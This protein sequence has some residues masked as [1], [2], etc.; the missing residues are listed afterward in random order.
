V[1]KIYIRLCA[2]SLVFAVGCDKRRDGSPAIEH[3]TSA[4]AAQPVAALTT[5]AVPLIKSDA[6]AS[7]REFATKFV[8]EANAVYA[9]SF[10]PLEP[11]IDVRKT[12]SLIAPIVGIVNISYKVRG[13]K[14][15]S[16]GEAVKT[17]TYT[18]AVE[19]EKW[20][21]RSAVGDTI[22]YDKNGHP[23][24]PETDDDDSLGRAA[25][26]A[27]MSPIPDESIAK[28]IAETVQK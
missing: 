23:F 5:S 2:L 16:V 22:L 20:V 3:S 28:R 8:N 26:D 4:P 18:F 24:P 10:D 13:D 6:T 21:L 25:R 1:V 12:E 7:F 17:S 15:S 14:N 19:N 11:K 27:R 9:S